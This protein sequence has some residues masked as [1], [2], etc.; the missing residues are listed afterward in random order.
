MSRSLIIA[1]IPHRIRCKWGC[2]TNPP[3]EMCNAELSYKR[4]WVS[5][6]YELLTAIITNDGGET[7]RLRRVSKMT[8]KKVAAFA[9]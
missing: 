7:W 4:V 3:H 5:G 9:L 1:V 6:E 8:I 2:N